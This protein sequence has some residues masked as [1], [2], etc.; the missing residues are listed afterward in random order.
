MPEAYASS[1]A[2]VHHEQ[3][4]SLMEDAQ[5]ASYVRQPP[6]WPCP[7]EVNSWTPVQQKIEAI[8]LDDTRTLIQ[9]YT[10]RVIAL[11][12]ILLASPVLL[13]LGL[14]IWIDSPGSPIFCQYR[15]GKNG[16]LFRFYKFRTLYRDARQRFPDLY[17]YRYSPDDLENLQFKVEQDPRVTRAGRFLRRSTLDELPNFLNVIT[18][19]MALVGP[20]PEIPEMLQY[21]R[22]EYL[23]KFCVKPGVTGLAQVSGRGRLLFRNTEELD[24]QSV[25]QRSAMGDLRLMLRTIYLIFKMDGAF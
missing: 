20:R 6:A 8:G 13:A 1:G 21:Y 10:E 5:R 16:K 2:D 24:A 12:C 18:G 3:K 9:D 25:L 7:N 4:S 17:S 15:V 14:Y 23:I 22:P 19:D 11:L